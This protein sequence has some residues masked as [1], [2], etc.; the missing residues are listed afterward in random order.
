M[1]FPLYSACTNLH[2]DSLLASGS[3]DKGIIRFAL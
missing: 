2:V 3:L 1:I